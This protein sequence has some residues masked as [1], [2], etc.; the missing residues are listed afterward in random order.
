MAEQNFT[1][2]VEERLKEKFEKRAD[3]EQR[4]IA[5]QLRWLMEAY[6]ENRLDVKE[7]SDGKR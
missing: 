6:V 2:A 3:L 7:D 5:G 4:T 1:F